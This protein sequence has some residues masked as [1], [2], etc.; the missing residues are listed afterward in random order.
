MNAN[1]D[2]EQEL[3]PRVNGQFQ[4]QQQAAAVQKPLRIFFEDELPYE[5][6]GRNL[7]TELAQRRNLTIQAL[8]AQ[9]IASVT[10]Y[11]FFFFRRVNL[12]T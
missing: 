6:S 7:P 1:N 11:G 10:G 3:V 5:Y 2:L 4:S 9:T 8:L 12:Q